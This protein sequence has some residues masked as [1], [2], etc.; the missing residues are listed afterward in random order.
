MRR[1][2]GTYCSCVVFVEIHEIRAHFFCGIFSQSSLSTPFLKMAEIYRAEG[3]QSRDNC[4]MA[5]KQCTK[6]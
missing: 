1:S 6:I 4:G 2:I 5:I 3:L